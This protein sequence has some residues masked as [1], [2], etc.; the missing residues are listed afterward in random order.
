MAL[1]EHK[2]ARFDFE[3]LD[4]IEAGLVLFGTEVKSLRNGQGKLEGAHVVVRG[5]EA[6]LVG[7]HI[8]PF[9][10]KN[11]PADYDPERSRRLL[12]TREQIAELSQKSDRQ[13]LTIVPLSVY[14]KGRNLKLSIGVARG[15]KKYDK[16]ETL[17]ARDTK[18]SIERKLKEQ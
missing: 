1:I 11:V 17:K 14:N 9:Q 3:I 6:F 10:A 8:P 13:G 2:R 5:G 4:T 15:K 7:A 16:R 18:R 12:I